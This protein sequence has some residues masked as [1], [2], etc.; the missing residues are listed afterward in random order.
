MSLGTAFLLA[1]AITG[2]LDLS[3]R[4]ELRL[5]DS[6][7]AAGRVVD[8]ETAPVA[9]L[10]LHSRSFR[11]SLAYLPRFTL[12]QLDAVPSP[13]A[14]HRGA[15]SVSLRRRRVELVVDGD[16]SR[17]T[18]I[19]TA[20]FG[21][22]SLDP[23]HLSVQRLPIT[24]TVDYL[25]SRA[26][27]TATF[28]VTRR[29]AIRALAEHALSGGA[30]AASR[31]VI[32]F[33]YGP[34]GALRATCSLS[35]HDS[36]TSTLDLSRTVFD[37]GPDNVVGE[38]SEA[39]RHVFDRRSEMTLGAGV[40]VVAA[41]ASAGDP[42]I[43]RPYA[44]AE[45][46]LRVSAP[47]ARLDTTLSLRLAPVV[48]RLSGIVDERLQGT[49][50]IAWSFTPS[51]ALR[52]QFGAAQSVQRSQAGAVTVLIGEAAFSARATRAVRVELGTRIA[53]QA[54]RGVDALPAQ[55][56]MFTG[57]TFVLPSLRF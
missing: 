57:A 50:A 45:G 21:V 11:V 4:S 20:L 30:D 18:T 38:A 55:W 48:D 41:R 2:A 43:T 29:W 40:S 52:T 37:T 54:S 25:S 31:E 28:A 15:L 16:V 53:A 46:T 24:P 3:D 27:V 26:G 39:F 33:Q 32:P 17:G 36:L 47:A 7:D 51:L 42:W 49:A 1:G 34:R 56:M 22:R 8:F 12:R 14:F 10:G 19:T 5:R 13:E 9:T 6:G 44:L 23:A 35:R